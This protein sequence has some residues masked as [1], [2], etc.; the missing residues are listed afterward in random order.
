[1]EITC[2]TDQ[3]I[4]VEM[5]SGQGPSQSKLPIGVMGHIHSF[6]TVKE[7]FLVTQWISKTVKYYL[8]Q[9]NKN[10]N[11]RRK[12]SVIFWPLNSIH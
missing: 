1:M 8:R 6:R 5:N 12:L 10:L 7:L 11:Q 9:N 3:M 2:E 4:D